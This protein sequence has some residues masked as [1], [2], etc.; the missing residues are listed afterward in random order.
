MS[1]RVS[2]CLEAQGSQSSF[3]TPTWQCQLARL[4]HHCRS[5]PGR[6]PGPSGKLPMANSSLGPGLVGEARLA[7]SRKWTMSPFLGP[8]SKPTA[9]QPP[10]SR[11]PQGRSEQAII[12]PWGDHASPPPQA[13]RRSLLGSCPADRETGALWVPAGHGLRHGGVG[14]SHRCPWEYTGD[15]LGPSFPPLPLL[16]NHRAAQDHPSLCQETQDP[17]RRKNKRVLSAGGRRPAQTM[18]LPLSVV[19]GCARLAWGTQELWGPSPSPCFW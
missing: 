10:V 12:V 5:T 14:C 18:E 4:A 15:P 8:S 6:G 7:L 1:V 3:P 17:A 19:C 11:L 9:P 16:V 13:L 2:L